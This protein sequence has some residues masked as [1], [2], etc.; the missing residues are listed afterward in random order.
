MKLDIRKRILGIH[1]V[2][3]VLSAAVSASTY[4]FG[5]E[6]VRMSRALVGHDVP[7]L[8]WV[9]VVKYDILEQERILYAYYATLGREKFQQGFHQNNIQCRA[10]LQRLIRAQGSEAKLSMLMDEY[11]DITKLA[12]RLDKAL[13]RKAP[14]LKQA[15]RLLS[16]I[17]RVSVYL[18][19]Q[20]DAIAQQ[21]GRTAQARSRHTENMI[22]RMNVAVIAFSISLFII[23]LLVGYFI[24]VYLSEQAERSALAM[25]P[26]RN[27]LPILRLAHNGDL[28]YANPGAY[29]ILRDMG[30]NANNPL[31]LLPADLT[32]RLSALWDS[33]SLQALWQ[34]NI[35][36]HELECHIHALP[37]LNILHVYISDVSERKIAERNLVFQAYHDPL[38]SLPNRRLFKER[39][40]QVLPTHDR[41]GMRAA[42]LLLGLDRFKIIIESFGHEVGDDLLRGV[43]ERLRR[44]LEENQHISNNA[45]LYRFETDLFAIFIPGFSSGQAPILLTEK[46]LTAMRNPFYN[47]G[48][49]FYISCSAGISI[50]PLDGLDTT[51]LLKNADTAMNRAKQQGG[52]NFQ[53]YTQDMNIH[54]A[55]WLTTENHLRHANQLGE[56]HLHY[57]P[58]IDIRSG[59]VIGM[60]ALLRWKHPH[61][62]LIPPSDFI[63]LAEET[64]II[65]SI[66]EWALRTACHQNKAWMDAGLGNMVIAVNIS[67]RQFHQ[68]DLPRLVAEILAESGMRP[69]CLELEITESAAMQDVEHTTATLHRLREMSVKVSIDDFGTGFSSLS[70]L[71]RFPLDKLKIDQS[72]IRHLSSDENDSA[73]TSAIITLGHSLKLRVIAEGVETMEQ[74]TYL[75]ESGCDEVQGLFFSSALPPQDFE[76]YLKK[77]T[78]TAQAA[79]LPAV[80][81]IS[82]EPRPGTTARDRTGKPR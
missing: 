34:Y 50:Y 11:D 18:G 3:L 44:L 68:Q 70:Y 48:R 8:Q 32:E 25:F 56:L 79:T 52:N 45:G 30:L 65:L 66:G 24:S 43:A 7:T 46:I 75:R 15:R 29:G 57:Q 77:S 1:L 59:K 5:T 21:V 37:D 20:L 9:A 51:T 64:G 81:A 49:E 73:I 36:E 14:D 13:Y 26:E 61:R 72:F 62:G 16:E 41:G 33:D 39:V 38:T 54:A 71:K 12:T 40:D 17:S 82:V 76:E 74:Y 31:A 4:Y 55:E 47:G 2:I 69:G 23:G 53:C 22:T 60:E 27:P 58:Q 10:S 19:H 35:N 6:V 67:A 28:L 78:V 42:I 80:A 63:P